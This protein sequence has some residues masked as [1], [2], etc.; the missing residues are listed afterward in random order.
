MIY[1]FCCK[2]VWSSQK[3]LRFVILCISNKIL[4]LGSSKHAPTK[5]ITYEL[6]SLDSI[7]TSRQNI[8]T[9]DLAPK[10]LARYLNSGK[11]RQMNKMWRSISA[12]SCVMEYNT[13][14]C[15]KDIYRT[16]DSKERKP[17]DWQYGIPVGS[18]SSLHCCKQT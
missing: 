12:R 17:C 7:A 1:R 11:W 4:T 3:C 2:S 16:L 9:S 13:N 5:L 10:E 18:G 14:H 6:F 8:S 15:Q